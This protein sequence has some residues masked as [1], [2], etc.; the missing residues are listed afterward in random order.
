MPP[1]PVF[2][3]KNELTGK[4][5]SS[6]SAFTTGQHGHAF[7][8]APCPWSTML[9]KACGVLASFVDWGA[10]PMLAKIRKSVVLLNH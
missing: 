4:G 7:S 5:L 3:P 1:L 9:S 10:I 6:H 8:S 2:M